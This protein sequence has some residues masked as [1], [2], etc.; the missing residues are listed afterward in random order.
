M[1]RDSRRCEQCGRE[2]V[3]GFRTIPAVFVDWLRGVEPFWN[4]AIT[5]C[6]AEKAC[7]ARWPRPVERDE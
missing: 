7:R 1:N 4:P 6:A 2:G 5:V 3:R